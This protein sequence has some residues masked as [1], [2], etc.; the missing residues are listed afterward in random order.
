[1]FLPVLGRAHVKGLP[2]RAVKAAA[3]FI[4]DSF[5]NLD[6]GSVGKQQIIDGILQ[7]DVTDQAAEGL[8]CLPVYQC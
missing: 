6:D 7:P 1:M 2:E 8:A 5:D 3:I 4:A